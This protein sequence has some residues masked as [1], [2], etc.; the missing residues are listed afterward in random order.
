MDIASIASLSNLSLTDEEKS[1]I[2]KEL[3]ETISTIA[4][5]NELPTENEMS[6]SQVTGLENILRPDEIDS[7]RQFSQSQ[8][9]AGSASTQ[10]GYFKVPKVL[11]HAK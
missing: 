8:A 4:V 11:T 5:I 2:S 1:S 9:L 7:A 10:D 3:S 6:T